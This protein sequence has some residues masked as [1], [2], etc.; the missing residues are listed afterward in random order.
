MRA[1]DIAEIVNTLNLYAVALDSHRYG[2]FEQVF[3]EDVTVD[4]GAGAAFTGLKT[5]QAGFEM[6]H[7]GFASTQHIT[8]GHVVCQEG[9]EAFAGSYVR[10]IFQRPVDGAKA[11]FDTTGWYDDILVRTPEGWRV[12]SWVSR[13]VSA[14]GDAQVMQT[15]QGAPAKYDVFS[16]A[17]EADADR[18]DF[19]KALDGSRLADRGRQRQSRT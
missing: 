1:G 5:L 9:Q 2:L 3:T 7:A 16:L 17:G 6:V 11:V 15:I 4:F 19:L 10:A 8:S 18:V 13:M 14:R 12:R